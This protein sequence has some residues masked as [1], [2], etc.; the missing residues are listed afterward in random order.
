M[1]GLGFVK[2]PS[3]MVVLKLSQNVIKVDM[4]V[5]KRL[6][7]NTDMTK[8]TACAA[9][10]SSEVGGRDDWISEDDCGEE[11]DGT[12]LLLPVLSVADAKIPFL[13]S[14]FSVMNK[15]TATTTKIPS[16]TS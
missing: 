6:I 2:D 10:E 3:M 7:S 16:M 11:G 5:I 9:C 8:I 12:I 14:R 4:N 1:T 13:L 15:T